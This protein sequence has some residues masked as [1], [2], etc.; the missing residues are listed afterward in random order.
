LFGA[1]DLFN[2]GAS[3]DADRNN[4]MRGTSG[5]NFYYSLPFGY[6]T[7]TLSAN[8]FMYHQRVNAIAQSFVSKGKTQNLEAKVSYLF[9]RD[10][11]SK[12]SLQFR[13]GKY[14]SHSYID[15]TEILVQRRNTT[16]AEIALIHKHN[17]GLAQIYATAA[18][19]WGTPWF[20]AQSDPAN[21]TATSPRFGYSLETLDVTLIMP[22]QLKQHALSYSSTF[23]AQNTNTA[24]YAD[25]WFSIGNRWTVRGFDGESALGAEKGFFLRNEIGIPIQ[26]TAQLAYIGLDFG[27][28]YGYN[29][30]TLPGNKLAGL[31][32]G[33]RGSAVQNMTYEVFAGFSLYKPDYFPTD[34]P[35]A[36]FS[37]MYQM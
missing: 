12:S 37:L 22:F 17:I 9:H 34:E 8:E 5:N 31:V 11:F 10:Q 25:Q 26:G 33:L 15:D 16:F 36:G 2:I 35:A 13:V 21:L 1:N 29:V 20:G 6:W 27:M 23:R 4:Y 14:F 30:A 28:V 24:L 3:T 7:N 19:R 32:A 18:Y